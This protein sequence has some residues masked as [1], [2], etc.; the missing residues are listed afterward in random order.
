[1][2]PLPETTRQRFSFCAGPAQFI[3]LNRFGHAVEDE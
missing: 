2:K 1:M 3:E